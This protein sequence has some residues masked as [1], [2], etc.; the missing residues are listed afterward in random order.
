MSSQINSGRSGLPKDSKMA[1]DLL[2]DMT[3]LSSSPCG[4]K[5]ST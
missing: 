2:P 3:K 4:T 5:V 1:G